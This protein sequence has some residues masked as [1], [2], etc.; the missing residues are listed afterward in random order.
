[1]ILEYTAPKA[2]P[3]TDEELV[4][5][6]L[7]RMRRAC[8]RRWSRVMLCLASPFLAVYVV[9]KALSFTCDASEYEMHRAKIRAVERRL[10]IKPRPKDP[11]RHKRT[12]VQ[13][14]LAY[15]KDVEEYRAKE[16]A[17]MRAVPVDW[18]PP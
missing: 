5:L 2:R 6:E 10:G 8:E 1:M 13:R 3:L 11:G 18:P 12:L 17:R 16:E 14:F 7:E 9:W 15:V 4:E